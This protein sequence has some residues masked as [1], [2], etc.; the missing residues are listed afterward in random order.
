MHSKANRPVFEKALFLLVGIVIG[1]LF[2]KYYSIGQLRGV[3]VADGTLKSSSEVARIE[4]PLQMIQRLPASRVMVA[5]TF[6]QSNSANL[7]ETPHVAG[8][9]VYN[10][11][12]GK[13]YRARDPLL[14]ADG[15][16]GSVWTRLGDKLIAAKSYDAVIFVSLGQGTSDIAQWQPQGRLLPKVLKAL[17]NLKDHNLT[18]THLFWHQG[19]AD[20][21]LQTSGAVYKSLFLKMLSAIRQEG[22]T[23]PIY[24]CRASLCRQNKINHSLK[25]AQSQLVN[26]SDNIRPGPDTDTLG[27]A[28]R[29]DGCHFS[30]QGLNKFA[31][32]WME[33]LK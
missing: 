4:V 1:I 12:E 17:R 11:Y 22:T 19:E 13:L 25:Q 2:Q 3:N 18:V 8:R 31:D 14:A 21:R 24:V 9:G 26:T 28:Y 33:K 5:V 10:F 16:G 29:Y 23:A 15:S 27:Y 30:D 7:G 32:L 20:N 6:G